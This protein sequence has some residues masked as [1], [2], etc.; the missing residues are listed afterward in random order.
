M[1]IGIM[2]GDD[3]GHE[4]VP[5]C[6]KVMQAAAARVRAG[7]RVADLPIG[8]HGHEEHGNTLP[9]ITEKALWELDGWI[10]GPIGHAAYPRNDPPG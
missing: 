9:E 5:E 6:V 1:K 8:K 10:M 7:D 3:I 2:L 4:V